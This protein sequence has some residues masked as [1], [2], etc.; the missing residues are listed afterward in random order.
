MLTRSDVERLAPGPV[1]LSSLTFAPTEQEARLIAA[2]FQALDQV[3]HC[4]VPSTDSDDTGEPASFAAQFGTA[5]IRVV[6][7]Q[8]AIDKAL[9]EIEALAAAGLKLSIDRDRTSAMQRAGANGIALRVARLAPAPR[10]RSECR[11]GGMEA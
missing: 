10:N 1:L 4:A 3:H 11:A 2:A 6:M 7:L 9:A 8:R 5:R